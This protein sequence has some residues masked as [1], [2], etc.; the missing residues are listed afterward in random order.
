MRD[1]Q[2]EQ[3]HIRRR[4]RL[5]LNI[6]ADLAQDLKPYVGATGQTMSGYSA[7]NAAFNVAIGYEAEQLTA[8]NNER[9]KLME[10]ENTNEST[11]I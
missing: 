11:S 6:Q 4:L 10:K 1:L 2:G 3:Y 9:M 5:L 8:L 7:L